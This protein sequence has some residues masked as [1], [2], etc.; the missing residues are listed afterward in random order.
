MSTL[1]TVLQ[2]EIWLFMSGLALIIAFQL[3]TRKINIEGLLFDGREQFSP[4]RVQLLVA[5]IAAASYY[6]LEILNSRRSGKFPE[7]PKEFFLI[8]GGSNLFYLGGK[9][10]SLIEEKLA[11][12]MSSLQTKGDNTTH[13]SGG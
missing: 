5:T 4:G 13:N 6:F 9:L 1:A 8:L 3:L 10:S 2:Y 12:I 7:L 11:S